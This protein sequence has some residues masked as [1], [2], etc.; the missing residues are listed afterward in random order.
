[1]I[2]IIIFDFNILLWHPTYL[3]FY[4]KWSFKFHK[5]YYTKLLLQC[6]CCEVTLG[7]QACVYHN[8]FFDASC[9]SKFSRQLTFPGSLSFVSSFLF[10]YDFSPIYCWMMYR[11]VCLL[12]RREVAY[13]P[14]SFTEKSLAKPFLRKARHYSHS[15]FAFASCCDQASNLL[16]P[17]WDSSTNLNV[18]VCRSWCWKPQFHCWHDATLSDGLSHDWSWK[19]CLPLMSCQPDN[20]INSNQRGRKKEGCSHFVHSW[21]LDGTK[22]YKWYNKWLS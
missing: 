19:H 6:F 21:L 8:I 1:M 17:Q 4:L 13:K 3:L 9:L 16:T 15:Q 14:V 11:V 18:T 12:V 5:S 10:F 20:A 7:F 2:F 22:T